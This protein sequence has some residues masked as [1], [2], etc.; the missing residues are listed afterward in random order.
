MTTLVANQPININDDD[1]E[2]VVHTDDLVLVVFWAPWCGSCR[3]LSPV[4]EKL[5]SDYG[6]ALTVAKVNIDDNQRKAEQFGVRATPTL[7][8]F[9]DG[10][11]VETLVG[12]QS[13]A[14]LTAA[15]ERARKIRKDGPSAPK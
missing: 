6:E 15:I 10:K 8:L 9:K 4:L 7:V 3:A 14:S 2:L 13:R 11:P 5:A 1:F 12:L